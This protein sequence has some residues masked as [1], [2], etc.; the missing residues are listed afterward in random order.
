MRCHNLEC[1]N[2]RFWADQCHQCQVYPSL[3]NSCYIKFLHFDFFL[4]EIHFIRWVYYWLSRYFSL[5]DHQVLGI[6]NMEV[7][8]ISYNYHLRH[9]YLIII[10]INILFNFFFF[11][12][13]SKCRLSSLQRGQTFREQKMWS[14]GMCPLGYNVQSYCTVH[15]IICI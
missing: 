13:K 10:I 11:F 15:I 5:S 6:R 7:K 12:N 4:P 8:I 9:Y 14:L 3:R 1:S 2:V